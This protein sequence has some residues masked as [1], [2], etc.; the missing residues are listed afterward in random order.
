MM[1][2]MKASWFPFVLAIYAA[3]IQAE[4]RYAKF[5][6][7]G[8]EILQPE[9]FS[10]AKEFQGLQH[11]ATG[12]VV[13]ITTIPTPFA[14]VAA[15]F[16]PEGLQKSGMTLREKTAIH[17]GGQQGWL[18]HVSLTQDGVEGGKWFLIVGE[19][20]TTMMIAVYP[21]QFESR[22]SNV[23]KSIVSSARP[24][25]RSRR[26]DHV[27]DFKV[28]PS[29]KLLVAGEMNGSL[30]YTRDGFMGNDGP[31]EPQV[32]VVYRKGE[33]PTSLQ[34]FAEQ[35]LVRLIETKNTKIESEREITGQP[36]RGFEIIATSED[37][38][39]KTP[40]LIYERLFAY[41]DG[42][43]V[44]TGEVGLNRRAEYLP[45][46]QSMADGFQSTG[47]EGRGRG[48]APPTPL[49]DHISGPKL[50][51]LEPG[52]PPFEGARSHVAGPG[53]L[54][55][56]NAPPGFPTTR[57]QM[58]KQEAWV[59]RDF[60]DDRS[61]HEDNEK[62]PSLSPKG[63]EAPRRCGTAAR[64]SRKKVPATKLP[65]PKQPFPTFQ[66]ADDQVQ[67]SAAMGSESG[68]AFEVRAP[69]GGVLVGVR[70]IRGDVFNGCVQGIEPIFQVENRYVGSR[71]AGTQG[72]DEH[73]LLAP[74]GYAVGG[75][76]IA[77]GLMMDA[78]RM[79]YFPLKDNRLDIKSPKPSEWVGGNG[80]RTRIII[81][82][83]GFI[84][85]LAGS[86]KD[87]LQS[88][89]LVYTRADDV[90]VAPPKAASATKA[91]ASKAEAAPE[92]RLWKS[93][94]GKFSVKAKLDGLDGSDVKLITEDGRNIT[95]PVEKLSEADQKVLKEY[96]EGNANAQKPEAPSGED[97]K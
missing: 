73:L 61:R 39:N 13:Q 87:T 95:V 54:G 79:F 22:L 88:I 96:A 10:V 74:P 50:K 48:P 55:A 70:V 83:G 25:E 49:P 2:T 21:N 94:S 33:I 14:E 44:L 35:V 1:R 27:A 62:H 51:S 90:T 93:S 89:A 31:G 30:I 60:Q 80:G 28:G 67:T 77:S 24:I 56:G 58:D 66:Y 4:E 19:K 41:S 84:V 53:G 82:D 92:L 34:F 46:F 12:C 57:G 71:L 45:D 6:D 86:H 7:C 26:P 38:S 64:D 18:A 59:P 3:P 16:T 20:T 72:E 8:V 63:P 69:N 40:I 23:L 32:I 65:R 76:E 81:G 11:D 9:G 78:I 91:V 29:K 37:T 5:P 43:F 68:D 15:R 52:G 17:I 75:I 36:Y 97:S 47:A 85:G 42:H